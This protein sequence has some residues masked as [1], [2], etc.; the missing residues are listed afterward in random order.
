MAGLAAAAAY[1]GDHV[2]SSILGVIFDKLISSHFDD[3][4][5]G[6]KQHKKLL[7]ELKGKL[8]SI[9]ALAD[10]A[11]HKQFTDQRVRNWLLEA[12]DVVFDAEDLL[13]EID[14]ELTK[15][16]VEAVSQSTNKVMKLL[17]S[18]SLSSFQK[19][20]ESRME[21]ILEKIDLLFEKT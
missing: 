21:Q 20:I 9:D 3:F 6:S 13:D 10:D 1:V 16:Q 12:E 14:Y 19:E 15:C 7:T 18:F 11:E 8:F 2:L 4:F 5:R 17:K